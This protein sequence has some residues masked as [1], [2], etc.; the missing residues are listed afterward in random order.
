[1][2]GRFLL[3]SGVNKIDYLILTSTDKD[4]MSGAKYLLENFD[5]GTV[6]TNG[7]KL[8][9]GL[10]ETIKEKDIPWEDLG[11]IDE[12]PLGGGCRLEV[13]RSGG[14]FIIK[15]SSLP[16]PLALKVTFGNESILTGETVSDVRAFSALAG[17]HGDRLKSDILYLPVLKPGDASTS[18]LE[19]VSPRI[20]VTGEIDRSSAAN[21]PGLHK[22]LANVAFFDT[23]GDGE[24]TVKTNGT[25]VSAGTYAG[26]REVNL[27]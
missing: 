12:V 6:I 22:A 23:S 14:D 13:L 8:A 9:G 1:M 25:N 18:F 7:D 4:H 26:K 16:R 24:V 2:A 3:H 10:W 19:T 17:I 11:D 5:V 15:D 20:L 27:K 21:D